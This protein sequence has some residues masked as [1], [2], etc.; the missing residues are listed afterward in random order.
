MLIIVSEMEVTNTDNDGRSTKKMRT[1]V[2][3]PLIL[4]ELARIKSSLHQ[5]PKSS[6]S[7][8]Q[9]FQFLG[10]IRNQLL[11]MLELVTDKYKPTRED[12]PLCVYIYLCSI[13]A[14]PCFQPFESTL[15]NIHA[16]LLPMLKNNDTVS[17]AST[18]YKN[19]HLLSPIVSCLDTK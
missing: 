14:N 12:K 10:L 17:L 9:D 3:Y 2:Q 7:A 19:M 6:V 1:T 5:I 4:D 18:S 8:E 15:F 13:P 11:A 16:L